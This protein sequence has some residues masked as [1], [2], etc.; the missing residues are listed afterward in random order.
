MSRAAKIFAV[1]KARPQG[2]SFSETRTKGSHHI[3]AK[4]GVVEIIDLQPI[5][6]KAKTYQVNQVLG[7]IE[8]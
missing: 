8:K 7:L 5:K 3:Y 1:A 4:V 6:G 2:L